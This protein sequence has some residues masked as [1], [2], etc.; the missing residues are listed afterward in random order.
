MPV[1]SD[2]V[3]V[4]GWRQGSIAPASRNGPGWGRLPTAAENCS[5]MDGTP[6]DAGFLNRRSRRQPAKS[7]RGGDWSQTEH[8]HLRSHVAGSRT[9]G[10]SKQRVQAVIDGPFETGGG[11]RRFEAEPL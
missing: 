8:C 2:L 4:V 3:R 1:V 9:I 10:G 7:A 11:G 5:A 6:A